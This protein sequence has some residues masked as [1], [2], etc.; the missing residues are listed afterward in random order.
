[1][2]SGIAIFKRPFIGHLTQYLFTPRQQGDSLDCI[3]KSGER[4]KECWNT[5][6]Y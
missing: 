2:F 5:N 6:P 4:V 3:S 1:M